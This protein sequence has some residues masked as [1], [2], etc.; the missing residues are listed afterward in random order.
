MY[1]DENEVL[2]YLGVNPKLANLKLRAYVK[3]GIE[4]ILKVAYPKYVYTLLDIDT[5]EEKILL[6]GTNVYLEGNSIKKSI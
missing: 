1:I 6:K 3:D 5:T 2:R 4:E